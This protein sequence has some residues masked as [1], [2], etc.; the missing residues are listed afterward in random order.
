MA[1]L[2]AALRDNEIRVITL[3]RE[4]KELASRLDRLETEKRDAEKQAMTSGHM[5]QQLDAEMARVGERLNTCQR[6]I[7]RLSF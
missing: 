6:E 5:L 7:Q 4:I 1:D 2:E 3:G